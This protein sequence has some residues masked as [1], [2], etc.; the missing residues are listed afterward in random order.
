MTEIIV[1]TEVCQRV[2]AIW[3]R[4]LNLRD[5]PLEADF[6]SLGGDSLVLLAILT[7]VENAFEVELDTEDVVQN[8]TI[9]GM[10]DLVLAR[11]DA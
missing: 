3:S 9:H 4:M 7:E 6:T 2:K 10:T 1:R 11:I 8:L 5:I